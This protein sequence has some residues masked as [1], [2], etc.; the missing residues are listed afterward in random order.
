MIPI[1]PQGACIFTGIA[2]N[3]PVLVQIDRVNKQLCPDPQE[4][5]L[6]IL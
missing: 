3:F 1:L 4:A 6:I 5:F 2:S